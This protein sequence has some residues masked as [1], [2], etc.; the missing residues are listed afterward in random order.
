[1]PA[2]TRAADDVGRRDSSVHGEGNG[3]ISDVELTVV[4]CVVADAVVR[5]CE[6]LGLNP[7]T[8]PSRAF[9]MTRLKLNRRWKLHRCTQHPL[10]PAQV[11]PTNVPLML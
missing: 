10:E 6:L 4:A 11:T 7:R 5:S 3:I 2:Q 9:R 8:C 1:M